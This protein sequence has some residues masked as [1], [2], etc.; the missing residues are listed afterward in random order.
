[1]A[2]ATTDQHQHTG[3]DHGHDSDVSHGNREN[4]PARSEGGADSEAGPFS[5]KRARA[6][7]CDKCDKSFHYP[8][9]LIEHKNVHSG[10]TP[11][12]CELE[13]CDKA[14]PTSDQLR[15]HAQRHQLRFTCEIC[16]K[17][18][19]TESIRRTHMLTHSTLRPFG[20][21]DPRCDKTFKTQKALEKHAEI[22]KPEAPQVCDLDGCGRG[23]KRKDGLQRHK[24][25]EH[26]VRVKKRRSTRKE[27]GVGFEDADVA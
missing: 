15:T 8:A 14:F 24:R 20:C 26:G 23:F 22:H 7:P 10:K 17:R 12:K 16:Q 25:N 9:R 11:F 5:L 2:G 19:Q 13:T 18:F 1:M 27:N 3:H 4:T 21:K 6:H